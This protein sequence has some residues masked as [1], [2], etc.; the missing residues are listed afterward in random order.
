MVLEG[1]LESDHPW[2]LVSVGE[3]VTFL[4]RLHDLVLEDHLALLELLHSHGVVG[5]A[6]LAKPYLSEGSLSDDLQRLEVIDGYLLAV[7]PQL[8]GLLMV[9]LALE[10]FLF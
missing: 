9:D 1:T 8:G 7:L 4:P 2:I 10:F 5:F 3:D 6:P